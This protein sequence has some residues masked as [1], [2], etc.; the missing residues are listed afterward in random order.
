MEA[1][2]KD[3]EVFCLIDTRQIQKFIFHANDFEAVIGASVFLKE[4]MMD[5][6][7][8]AVNNIDEPLPEDEYDLSFSDTKGRIPWFVDPKIKMQLIMYAA[9]NA[10]ILFRTGELCEKI[11]HKVSRYHLDHCYCIDLA[12]SVVE[13]TDVFAD[14]LNTLYRRMD[15]IKTDFPSAH[16][17]LPLPVTRVEKNTGEPAYRID[18]NGEAISKS[19]DIRRAAAANLG[20]ARHIHGAK[21]PDGRMYRAAMHIDGNNMGIVIGRILRRFSDYE[22]A[23]RARRRI[24]AN[25]E[26]SFTGLVTDS[27]SWVRSTYFDDSVTD[28]E[29]AEYISITHFGGDDINIISEPHYAVPFMRHLMENLDSYKIWDEPDLQVGISVCGGIA[30][31]MPDLSYVNA[32]G[33]AD[34][35]CSIAKKEAKREQNQVNGLAG[36]WFDF[37]FLDSDCPQSVERRRE[38]ENITAEGVHLSLGPYSF[39]ETQKD[40]PRHYL[41]LFERMEALERLKLPEHHYRLL[42]ESYVLGRVDYELLIERVEADGYPLRKLLGEPMVTIDSERYATWY[43]AFRLSAVYH[44]REIISG[45]ERK[46]KN[47]TD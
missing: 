34:D 28:E 19:T 31:V 3:K 35:C 8:Y 12:V 13:K 10:M 2:L 24:A 44:P 5:A 11:I 41:K 27:L 46:R 33:S 47:G 45:K 1:R 39:D 16:P 9:G 40:S 42:S 32:H 18:E 29:F 21:G 7:H 25:I 15:R 37:D 4:V 6:L 43:D 14:D 17:L 26:N 36:N 22:D 23:I 30:F 20:C 38:T